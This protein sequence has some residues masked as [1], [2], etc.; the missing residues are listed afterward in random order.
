MQ[1]HVFSNQIGKTSWN[2]KN[3][4]NIDKIWLFGFVKVALSPNTLS[5]TVSGKIKGGTK[6][7][8]NNLIYTG[9]N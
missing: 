8:V 1:L 3:F 9:Q 4:A 5:T 6:L 7:F 2:K